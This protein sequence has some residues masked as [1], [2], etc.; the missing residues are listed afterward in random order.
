MK[1]IVSV[2]IPTR[3][4]PLLVKRAVQSVLT[5]T[6]TELE[7]IVVIDGPDRATC[8][9]LSEISDPRLK[10][11][12]LQDSGGA[13]R[14][15]NIGVSEATGEWIAFLDDDD[16]WLPR[17]L[18]LQFE[19]ASRSQYAFPI[20]ACCLIARTPKGEFVRPRRFLSP[21]EPISEYLLARNTLFQGEGLIQTSVIFTKKDL[22]QKVPFRQDLRRHQDWDWLLRVSALE[23]VG[24][25]FVPE[26]LAIWYVD[27]KRKSVSS[28]SNWQ[29][30][31]TWI[32]ENRNLVTPRAYS[33]FIMLEV[34][35][36]ASR[37]G[38]WMAFWPLLWEALRIGRPKPI[39]FFLYLGMWL[40]PQ[41]TRRT[42]RA[43]L[44]KRTQS[45]STS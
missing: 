10:V 11:T 39:D 12:E 44:S 28:T 5:Q 8:A 21:S 25:E 3:N 35:S 7:V 18:E 40:L 17:K 4:R 36:Q 2:V 23:G 15:R 16:E 43:L 31:L 13:A 24:I 30:S 22:L 45:L 38:Q 20:V 32:R 6:F 14:A 19:V 1:G 9:V 26:P 33:A 41:D 27:E 29:N 42:L 34:G 37:Q